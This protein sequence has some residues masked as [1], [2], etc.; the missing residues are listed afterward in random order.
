MSLKALALTGVVASFLTATAAPAASI[1]GRWS[2]HENMNRSGLKGTISSVVDFRPDGTLHL[3]LAMDAYK[4]VVRV[5]AEANY[6]S[7]WHL[8]GNRL[9]ERADSATVTKFTV[10]GLDKTDSDYATDFRSELMA[11]GTPP[12]VVFLADNRM[13]MRQPGR[14]TSCTR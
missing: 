5:Y 1:D 12:E 14:V 3:S 11:P 7:H 8:E 6:V 9:I 2:C 4:L 13:E 10:A